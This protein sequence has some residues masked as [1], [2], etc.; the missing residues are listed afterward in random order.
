M[1]EGA[2]FRV[3]TKFFQKL[4]KDPEILQTFTIVIFKLLKLNLKNTK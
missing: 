1:V 3:L 2:I 4:E